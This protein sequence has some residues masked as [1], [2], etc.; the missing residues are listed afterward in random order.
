MWNPFDVDELDYHTSLYYLSHSD[1]VGNLRLRRYLSCLWLF[2]VHLV[3]VNTCLLCTFLCRRVWTSD[4]FRV[5]IRWASFCLTCIGISTFRL[6]RIFQNTSD[7]LLS[8]D[9][10]CMAL[11]QHVHVY[12]PDE[13]VST[14]DVLR[15]VRDHYEGTEFDMS[16]GIAAGE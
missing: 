4:P 10:S 14:Q 12:R 1:R 8:F 3:S 13:L 5:T 9:H 2:H 11:N 15:I 16:Q 6:F 7:V